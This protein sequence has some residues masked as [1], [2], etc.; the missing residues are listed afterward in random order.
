MKK[1]IAALMFLGLCTV[2]VGCG[3]KTTTTT[4]QATTTTTQAVG[5]TQAPI[6]TGLIKGE[7]SPIEHLKEEEVD[8]Y[9]N[10]SVIDDTDAPADIE[11]AIVNDGG[12]NKDVPGVYTLVYSAT[13]KAGNVGTV[14]RTVTVLETVVKAYPALI[15]NDVAIPYF[16]EGREL[17][18]QGVTYTTDKAFDKVSTGILC[19]TVDE[20]TL[21]DYAK[22]QELFKAAQDSGN[23]AD[24]GHD[25]FLAYG[26]LVVLDSNYT[27]VY[28]RL[29]KGF[30][31]EVMPDDTV[32]SGTEA[33]FLGAEKSVNKGGLLGRLDTVLADLVAE[34]HDIAYVGIVGNP[35][36]TADDVAIKM[37]INATFY[38][39]YSG[40]A[41]AASART[42]TGLNT[43]VGQVK[44]DYKVVVAKPDALVVPTFTI[45][46]NAITFTGVDGAKY[47]EI[48]VDGTLSS[49]TIAHQG[50]VEHKV[51]LTGDDA[52]ALENGTYS[53]QIRA[54]SKDLFKWSHSE[55]SDSVTYNQID[56]EETIPAVI[57][58]EGDTLNITATEGAASYK[59]Y[60]NCTGVAAD[61]F[62]GE[63]A[64]LS[65]DLSTI[66]A[67]YKNFVS[68][69]VVA[70]GD[71][72]HLDSGKSNE[73]VYNFAD[74]KPLLID[75]YQYSVLETTY[76]DYFAR[77][78]NTFGGSSTGY[79]G[80][81]YIVHVTN[82]G[83][84]KYNTDADLAKKVLE[85]YS[86]V[87][88]L[89]KNGNI[90]Y[91]SNIMTNFKYQNGAWVAYSEE[92]QTKAN[93]N[94]LADITGLLNDTD[95]LLIFKN[96]NNVS[97][98]AEDG[99]STLTVNARA[100]GAYHFVAK[101]E[102]YNGMNAS[103]TWKT[104]NAEDLVDLSQVS[105]SFPENFI[106]KLAK[107][108]FTFENGVLNWE[109]VD[110]AVKYVLYFNDQTIEL[111]NTVN[112]FDVNAA[113]ST[114]A[115][116]GF[117]A[118]LL[119]VGDNRYNSVYSDV[120]EVYASKLELKTKDGLSYVMINVRDYVD[121]NNADAVPS[122]HDFLADVYATENG[123]PID[124]IVVA[125]DTKVSF[126]YCGLYVVRFIAT[127]TNGTKE[128]DVTY[129]VQDTV[130][131]YSQMIVG[132]NKSGKTQG[133]CH[134]SHNFFTQLAWTLG[135]DR[136]HV[137]TTF[138]YQAQLANTGVTP[139]LP[140]GIILVYDANMNL[141]ALRGS[142][143]ADA[144]AVPFE[145]LADGTVKTTDLSFNLA[146]EGLLGG[147]D[148]IISSLPNGGYVVY[149]PTGNNRTFVFN[150]V[151]GSNY[152]GG[153]F[154]PAT[155]TGNPYDV[156]VRFDIKV[157]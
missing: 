109:T 128:L 116:D 36:G 53:V 138:Y 154:D 119:A 27:P 102:T 55:L 93:A 75:G 127:G 123:E 82:F 29:S 7:L 149:T 131:W 42:I 11:I 23:Y 37:L 108:E 129:V 84:Y 97:V 120:Y 133:Y 14:N 9:S 68:I 101:C 45:S 139:V 87:V 8:L 156:K 80:V 58:I 60:L 111:A 100:I 40:G 49:F 52:L 24:N 12:Y 51:L 16:G 147:M 99:M 28:L 117:S 78:N 89:D 44:D 26:G 94:N 155:I 47:Y 122:E 157:F 134:Q 86:T 140:Q 136:V 98:I 142:T 25:P 124:T 90:K 22:F 56:L 46:K 63:T 77:R 121:I 35:T 73:V 64:E 143:G 85:A 132:E 107:P 2:A 95:S 20:M 145:V 41:V 104:V 59:V 91:V 3:N 110:G 69:Y 4:T 146:T 135:Q 105:V 148:D 88:V 130:V 67:T 6:F 141:V 21:L 18:T 32:I 61:V 81:P 152:T 125:E 70:V 115:E 76:Q 30:A 34:G 83:Q 10:I 50:V 79:A 71:E 92:E 5:D 43:L 31:V 103:Q 54:F 72:T 144:D 65:Y 1:L 57:A 96:G 106:E 113:L 118:K 62:V 39:E 17:E 74:L 112:T 19:A 126:K 33:S 38:D 151:L 15:I 137:Y 13:D 66:K 48:Y 114:W 150:H 153:V